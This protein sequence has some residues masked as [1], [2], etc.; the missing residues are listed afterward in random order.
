MTKELDLILLRGPRTD[1]AGN[2][3][4]VLVQVVRRSETDLSNYSFLCKQEKMEEWVPTK[5][6]ELYRMLLK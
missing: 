1:D 6:L 2:K 5:E 4:P 3:I